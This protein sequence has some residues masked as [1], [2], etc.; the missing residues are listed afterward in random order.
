MVRYSTAELNCLKS[1]QSNKLRLLLYQ[2]QLG[3][4]LNLT[5]LLIEYHNG[6]DMPKIMSVNI[7]TILP[8]S[9]G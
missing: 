7:V 2:L 3:I 9:T 5:K 1:N 6:T 4:N 8:Q